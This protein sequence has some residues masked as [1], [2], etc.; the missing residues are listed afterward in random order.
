[1]MLTETKTHKNIKPTRTQT[2]LHYRTT[3]KNKDHRVGKLVGHGRGMSLYSNRPIFFQA[4]KTWKNTKLKAFRADQNIL[5]H[6]GAS[7]SCTSCS[8]I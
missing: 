7:C 2:E 4:I 1:M 8:Q 3:K 6:E 5:L